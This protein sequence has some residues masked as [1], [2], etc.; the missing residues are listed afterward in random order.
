MVYH[1][2]REKKIGK[3]QNIGYNSSFTGS[4]EVAGTVG[5]FDDTFSFQVFR[6]FNKQVSENSKF[7]KWPPPI[8]RC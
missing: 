2:M 4:N 7:S 8:V 1:T 5:Y 3:I 6:S